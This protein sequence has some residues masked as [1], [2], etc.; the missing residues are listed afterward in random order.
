MA[1]ITILLAEDHLVVREG[2]RQLLEAEKDMQV[3]AEAGSGEEAVR[4]CG[5]AVPDLVLMDI[6]LAGLNGVEAT[7]RIKAAQPGITVLVLSAYDNEEFIF[8]VLQAGAAGYLLK[9]MRGREIVSAIRAVL[10]GDSI[11]HPQV[12]AKVL[13]RLQREGGE[14]APRKKEPLSRREIEVLQLGA[15]GLANKEIAARL[16]LSERTIQSH[17]RNVFVKL[18]VSSRMEAVMYALKNGWIRLGLIDDA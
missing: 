12:A 3:I 9:N 7:R 13:K 2:L 4:L 5:T 16:D 10:D 18:G 6:S 17:W 8:A 15:G 1:E 14:A 11:L